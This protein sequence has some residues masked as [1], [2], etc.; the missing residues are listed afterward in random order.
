MASSAS[1]QL[2]VFTKYD[3]DLSYTL[4]RFCRLLTV[5]LHCHSIVPNSFHRRGLRM[6]PRSQSWRLICLMATLR[7]WKKPVLNYFL[8]RSQSQV[9]AVP[10]HKEQK[11]GKPNSGKGQEVPIVHIHQL[12][13]WSDVFQRT[14][15]WFPEPR[16]KLTCNSSSRNPN[17]LF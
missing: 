5:N 8:Q 2:T 10:G 15:V 7:P 14:R 17:T 6:C 11:V 3:N 1:R 13:S 16:N 4:V 9:L 12:W